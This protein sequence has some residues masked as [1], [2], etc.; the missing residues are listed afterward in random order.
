MTDRF[1]RRAGKDCLVSFEPSRYSIPATEVTAGMTVELRVGPETVAIH[2]IGADPRQLTGHRRA[3]HRGDDQIDLAHWEGLP[4]GHTRAVTLGDPAEQQQPLG[5]RL[6]PMPLLLERPDL[7]V[8]VARRD[9]RV[10][11]QAAGLAG[12]I[13]RAA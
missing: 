12:T 5:D 11:D 10:Y 6:E 1:L 8:A 9:P 3:R 7:G 2:A 13:G 4:D